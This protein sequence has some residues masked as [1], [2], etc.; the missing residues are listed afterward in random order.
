MSAPTMSGLSAGLGVAVSLVERFPDLPVLSVAVAAHCPDRVDLTAYDS[1]SAFEKW[2][3]ALGI[4]PARV[5]MDAERGVGPLMWLEAET[6]VD[7]VTARLV[8][9][10]QVPADRSGK[11]GAV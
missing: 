9:F 8:G 10:G 11:P 5:S 7:G 3:S 1:L 6:V 2:R 4:D